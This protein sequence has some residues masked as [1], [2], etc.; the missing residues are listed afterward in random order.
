[1][2]L[3]FDPASVALTTAPTHFTFLYSTGSLTGVVKAGGTGVSGVLVTVTRCQTAA[4][5]PSPPAAGACA[6]KHGSPSP[7]ISN[8]DT[9]ASGSYSV[10]GLL[11]GIYQVDVAPATVG[12]TRVDAPGGGSY[13]VV[14]KGDGDND[15]VPDFIIS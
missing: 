12:Y 6:L 9:D 5:E 4:S 10:S 14:I 1:M 3:S 7:H 11:E 2:A 15:V 8:I 13:L